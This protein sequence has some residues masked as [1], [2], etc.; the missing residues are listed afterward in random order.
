MGIENNNTYSDETQHRFKVE[1]MASVL[2][3]LD[4]TLDDLEKEYKKR[5]SNTK[6]RSLL[7]KSKINMRW[8]PIMVTN[9]RY[10]FLHFTKEYYIF[11]FIKIKRPFYHTLA[12]LLF[13]F[14]IRTL[15]LTSGWAENMLFPPYFKFYSFN[16]RIY[17]PQK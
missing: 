3:E 1:L 16:I 14:L 10:I 5:Y 4:V 6:E 11:I 17:I 9:N 12:L 8:L 7:I 13:T 15:I 2:S